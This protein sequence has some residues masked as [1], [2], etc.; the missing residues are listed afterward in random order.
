MQTS[1]GGGCISL[2]TAHFSDVESRSSLRCF[3]VSLKALYG[4]G[5]FLSPCQTFPERFGTNQVFCWNL[6]KRRRVPKIHLLRHTQTILHSKSTN[7][8]RHRDVCL[9]SERMSPSRQ[10]YFR[11]IVILFLLIASISVYILCMFIFKFELY[12]HFY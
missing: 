3:D 6:M 7:A 9:E 12:C 4:S 10:G 8:W 11:I 2:W 5:R 1:R